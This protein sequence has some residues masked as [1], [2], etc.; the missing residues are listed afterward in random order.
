MSVTV[1]RL[2]FLSIA[3]SFIFISACS[4][5]PVVPIKHSNAK[6]SSE[7][8][9][10]S[11]VVKTRLNQQLA[12]WKN[13]KYKLGGLSKS[14]IDCSGFVYLTFRDEFGI[15]LPRTT[16]KQTEAGHFVKQRNLKAGDLVFFK[17]SWKVRHVGIYM[18]NGKFIHA[19][20]SRGVTISSLNNRYWKERYWKAVRVRV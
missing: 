5:S 20:T 17:T 11:S 18:D 6:Y 1:N 8:L 9:K 10:D 15:G 2:K 12:K 16:K 7:L 4:N 19:S 3:L 13:V 14:G